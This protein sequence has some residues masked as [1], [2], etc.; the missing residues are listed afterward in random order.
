N[1]S[2]KWPVDETDR[3]SS[4]VINVKSVGHMDEGYPKVHRY[5]FDVRLILIQD[6]PIHSALER[7]SG[8]D[9]N[10][11]AVYPFIIALTVKCRASSPD[12]S[13]RRRAS[14][15]AAPAGYAVSETGTN[16]SPAASTK[17][18]TSARD[19]NTTS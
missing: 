5:Q 7:L 3:S 10:K 15:A 9:S 19:K 1:S 13:L 16:G 17:G 18:A 11:D 8:R 4:R 12:N 14:L 6:E 2:L